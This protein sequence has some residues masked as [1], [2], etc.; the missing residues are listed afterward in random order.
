MCRKEAL[1]R[2]QAFT[3]EHEPEQTF[4]T[5]FI[6]KKMQRHLSYSVSRS[7]H[8]KADSAGTSQREPAAQKD[9]GLK[10]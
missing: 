9:Y 8:V 5:N 10:M 3:Q 7:H 1:Q 2:G 4:R 6:T